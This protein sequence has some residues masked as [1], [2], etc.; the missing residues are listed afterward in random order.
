MEGASSS[1]SNEPSTSN[2]ADQPLQQTPKEQYRVMKKR[3]KFLVYENECYQE[4]LRNLQRKLL[5]LSRD[6]NFLLD[7]LIPFEKLSDSSDESDS[8]SAKVEE[9]PKPKRKPRNTTRKKPTP[10]AVSS[11]NSVK[12]EDVKQETID[13]SPVNLSHSQ[14]N[15]R[16]ANATSVTTMNG[17]VISEQ[18]PLPNI[19]AFSAA[20]ESNGGSP[21]VTKVKAEFAVK[22]V[23]QS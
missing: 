10:P 13:E 17:G 11:S 8:S 15:G 2:A 6:K 20:A 22:T 1:F 16:E 3:F 12:Q 23:E 14:L 7:R 18:K 4:E 5:K 19:A 9:K 21:V